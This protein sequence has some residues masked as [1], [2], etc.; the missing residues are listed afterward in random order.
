[1]RFLAL[2]LLLATLLLADSDK[3][4]HQERHLPLDMSYLELTPQQHEQ[5]RTIVKTYKQ[6]YKAFHHLKKET[7]EAVSKL[8]EAERFDAAEF[9]RLTAELNQRAAEIQAEFFAR[10]HA[11]LSPSQKKQFVEYMEEW[12]VE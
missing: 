11:I 9:V 6:Q 10:M 12:E 3:H 2:F 4:E 8:F 5:A 1:M 7:R